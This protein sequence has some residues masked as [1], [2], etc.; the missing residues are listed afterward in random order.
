MAKNRMLKS[1]D[2]PFPF[3]LCGVGFLFG[4][5]T[6]EDERVTK[7]MEKKEYNKKKMELEKEDE[8]R[9]RFRMRKKESQHLEE[10]IEVVESFEE[11]EQQEGEWNS[12]GPYYG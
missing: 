7:T 5:G 9:R 10:G 1:E 3:S 6:L 4:D 8:R 2:V 12:N 11:G